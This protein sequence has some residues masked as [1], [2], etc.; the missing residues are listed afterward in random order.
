MNQGFYLCIE[1]L[2]RQEERVLSLNL[3]VGID[4]FQDWFLKTTYGHI[5]RNMRG[6][7]LA[8]KEAVHQCL[9]ER[10]REF[11]YYGYAQIKYIHDDQEWLDF[12]RPLLSKSIKVG[13]YE[14]NQAK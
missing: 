4:L 2:H 14:I 1:V 9:E 3:E 11:S 13:L 6:T 7:K 12:V 8:M 5:T 10:L